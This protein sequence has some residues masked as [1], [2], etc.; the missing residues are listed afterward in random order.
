MTARTKKVVINISALVTAIAGAI[1][2]VAP[3]GAQIVDARYVHTDSFA[4]LR[5]RDSLTQ[6]AEF[7]ELHAEVKEIHRIVAGL[8][9]AFHQRRRAP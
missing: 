8:D 7:R 6:L 5:Q 2:W 9:T 3:R 4:L 1:A